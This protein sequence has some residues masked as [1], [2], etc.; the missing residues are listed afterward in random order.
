MTR[1]FLATKR[2]RMKAFRDVPVNEQGFSLLECSKL[3]QT[4]II[5]KLHDKELIALLNFLDPD[6]VADILQLIRK[7]RRKK[8]WAELE[9]AIRDKVEFLL[10]FDPKTAAG[11]MSL[12][13]IEV[14]KNSSAE[15]IIKSV[16]KH[17]RKTG[18][19]PA[20][21][22]VDGG[23]LIGELSIHHFALEGK[24][25]KIS[26]HIKKIHHI[27]YNEKADAIL[28]TFRQNRHGKIVVL[29]D[30][31]SILGVIYTDDVL[32]LIDSQ[33]S[34][35]LRKFAG[36][37]KEEDTQDG[38]ITKVKYRYKWLILN[39]FTAFL[40]AAVISLFEGTISR[41]VILAAYL[42]IVA[43]MG[44]NAATQTLAVTVRGMALKEINKE[45]AKKIVLNEVLAGVMNGVITGAVAAGIAIFLDQG[46]GIGFVLAAAMVANLF[47][48][49]FFGT[50][51]PLLMRKMGKDPASSATI[52]IT[53][54]TDVFGFLAFLGLATILL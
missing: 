7:S 16:R 25:A 24:K 38:A 45:N 14:K 1:I 4:E 29:D 13:Y 3:V 33:I 50:V 54:A 53:T 11:M 10:K 39:L 22:V 20:V 35:S 28:Q 27:C 51:I 19:V 32:K 44:G 8:V 31:Q 37:N 41:M 21:L 26:K 46:A 30:N 18:R 34:K 52:F 23:F 36:V 12:D 49:G 48:A 43:G 9:T 15:Y 42:P 17:E 47:I 5:K 6:K 2:N 40:A